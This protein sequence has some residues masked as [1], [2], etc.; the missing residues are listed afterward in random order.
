MDIAERLIAFK[1]YTGLTNSQFADKAGIPR[2]TLSQ[3]L[4]GRNKRLSDDLAAKLHV[5]YPQ[6]NVMWLLFG[7]GDMVNDKNIEF[8]EG[9][10]ALFSEAIISQGPDLSNDDTVSRPMSS[11]TDSEPNEIKPTEADV[12]TTSDSATAFGNHTTIDITDTKQAQSQ[13]AAP[14]I[15]ADPAKKIQSIMVFYSDNSYEIFTPRDSH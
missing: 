7:E 5:A 13:T 4:N 1:D 12:F 2:P 10:N 14:V 8:S 9:K 3:F 11:L 6:L 15:P